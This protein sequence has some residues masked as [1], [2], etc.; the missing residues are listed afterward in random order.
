MIIKAACT[1]C[2]KPMVVEDYAIGQSVNCPYCGNV[3][4]PPPP[5]NRQGAAVP[6]PPGPPKSGIPIVSA[7][8]SPPAPPPR[9]MQPPSSHKLPPPSGVRPAGS[10][11]G[12]QPQPAGL[13]GRQPAAVPIV[14]AVPLS[15]PR[16]AARLSTAGTTPV[17]VVEAHAAHPP[18]KK[19]KPVAAGIDFKSGLWFGLAALMLLVIAILPFFTYMKGT[20]VAS[21]KANSQRVETFYALSGDGKGS[22]SRDRIAGD[23]RVPLTAGQ[24]ASPDGMNTAAVLLMT[25]TAVVLLLGFVALLCQI[26]GPAHQPWPG[27]IFTIGMALL[28]AWSM[29]CFLWII[30]DIWKVSSASPEIS[31]LLKDN[32][33]PAFDE[34]SRGGDPTVSVSVGMGLWLGLLITLL[35]MV[36]MILLGLR[37]RKMLWVLIAYGVGLMIGLVIMFTLIQP[38]KAEGGFIGP[39]QQSGP[40]SNY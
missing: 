32:M 28:A 31:K 2:T 4:V 34:N 24:P 5:K 1:A 22:V 38:T 7:K 25:M 10:P 29:V 8:S 37:R 12:R 20:V 13:S 3:F 15:A 9:Q 11:S 30:G 23:L 40:P 35:A 6:P 33:R 27:Q 26:Y 39:L 19:R 17:P 21:D 36:F 18:G 14:E 16:S